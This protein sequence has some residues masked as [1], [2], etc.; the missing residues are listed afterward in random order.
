[1]NKIQS[2]ILTAALVFI[3]PVISLSQSAPDLAT[4]TPYVLFTRAGEVTSQSPLALV[5]GNVGNESG[6]TLALPPG[7]L[8]GEKHW[9]DA[10]ATQVGTAIGLAYAEVAAN[11]CGIIHAGGY[12]V[13][14]T[15]VPGVYCTGSAITLNGNLTLDAGNVPGAV[16]IFKIDGAFSSVGGSQIILLNGAESC[17]IFWQINGLVALVNTNFKGTML[18]NG[19]ITLGSGT[20]LDGRAL[21]LAGAVLFGNVRVTTCD[22]ATL[23]LELLSFNVSKTIGDNVNITWVT[24]TEVDVLRYEVEAS[25]NGTAFYKVN[26]I[27]SKGTNYPSQ[28]NIQDIQ[29]NK[30]GV[31]FYRLKMI[32]KD[33]SFTY[34]EIKSIKFSDLKS[35]LINI[36]PNPAGSIINVSVNAEVREKVMLTISNMHG[37]KIRQTIYLLNKGINNIKEN[38]QGLTKASYIVTIKNINTGEQTRQNI[39]K[40]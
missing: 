2:Y 27:S 34:S 9:W 16:F 3:S 8:V 38:I 28:Y 25:I 13:G 7:F 15:L 31:R 21:S 36:F 11:T 39:Q 4:A 19:A 33:G 32:D 40:L 29:A 12:G 23:P 26:T 18:V 14:E 17:N 1:M 22:V 24:A 30:T 10:E 37:Q 35:G 5:V 6:D 20:V